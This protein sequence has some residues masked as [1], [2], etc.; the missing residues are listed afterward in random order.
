MNNI[1]LVSISC[2]TFNHEPYIRQCLDG[3]IMQKT[4]FTFE[5]LIHDDASTDR[6][7][8]IIREYESKYPGI[9]KPI[10]Q[11]EN[12][13]SKGV[14]I[15]PINYNRAVGKY[16]AMCEGDDYWTD[17][18]KLQ[19]QVDFLETHE[20]VSMC[21]HDANVIDTE[22][23][24]VGNFKR[25]NQNQYAL[26]EEILLGRG[27]FIP[28][29]SIVFEAQ[30]V[31]SGYPDY[32]LNCHVGDF[33]LQLYLSAKGKVF[34]FNEVMS[35]YRQNAGNWTHNF[36]QRD[37]SLQV[38]GWMSEFI[39]TDG[40]NALL[41]YKYADTI[42]QFQADYIIGIILLPHRNKKTEIKKIFGSYIEKFHFKSKIKFFLICHAF[43]FY[44]LF[45]KLFSWL[46]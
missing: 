17:P 44:R 9:I 33:P 1:P 6:T 27:G 45:T 37:F 28:T 29:A 36:S 4:N 19:K 5:V 24:I 23:N 2:F 20:D 46:H 25:Y 15:D 43:F 42:T 30:F 39:V 34:Y 21:F 13:Y 16:I 8:N 32:C 26:I 35:V 31:K 40:I 3:F 11:T 14:K 38:N 22:S 7:A 10:Y 18:L 41:D 12:Q